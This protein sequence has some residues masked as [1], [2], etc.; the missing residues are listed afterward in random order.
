LRLQGKSSSHLKTG[1][2]YYE[3]LVSLEEQQ[4]LADA[5][6][7]NL[8]DGLIDEN[9]SASISFLDTHNNALT[10]QTQ[11]MLLH[12]FNHATHHRGQIHCLLTQMHVEAPSLDLLD[13]VVERSE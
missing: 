7:K 13:Y 8:V 12:M 1:A 6:L 5:E 2:I 4:S 11:T 3:D 9:L 10:L